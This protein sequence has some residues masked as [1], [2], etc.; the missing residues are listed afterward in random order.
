[1]D[2]DGDLRYERI[3]EDLIA[4]CVLSSFPDVV[5]SDKIFQT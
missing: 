3:F 5:S 4:K 1:M 2:S